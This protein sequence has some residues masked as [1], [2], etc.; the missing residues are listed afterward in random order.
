MVSMD[1]DELVGEER[2]DRRLLHE[3]DDMEEEDDE[4]DE[5]EDDDGGNGRGVGAPWVLATRFMPTVMLDGC[6]CD[7]GDVDLCVPWFRTTL[8]WRQSMIACCWRWARRVCFIRCEARGKKCRVQ[9]LVDELNGPHG[10]GFFFSSA[11]ETKSRDGNVP[12]EREQ[13]DGGGNDAAFGDDDAVVD[14]FVALA[15]AMA[16]ASEATSGHGRHSVVCLSI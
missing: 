7:G 6:V 8:R 9:S 15:E 2:G 4:D 10:P 12:G 16:A 11:S 14:G 5:E 13:D 1:E 3:D